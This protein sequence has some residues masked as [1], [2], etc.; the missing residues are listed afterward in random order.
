MHLVG[1]FIQRKNT[2]IG[3]ETGTFE[4]LICTLILSLL[5]DKVKNQS[6]TI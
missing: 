3:L 1:C 4:L 6:A 5:C 2:K